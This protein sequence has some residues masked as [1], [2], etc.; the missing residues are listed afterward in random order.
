MA[1]GILAFYGE[2][3]SLRLLTCLLSRCIIESN[4]WYVWCDTEWHYCTSQDTE[5][6]DSYTAD[7]AHCD[8]ERPTSMQNCN[9]A[10][11]Y[12]RVAFVMH[13]LSCGLT[14][15]ND[16]FWL[17]SIPPS[18]WYLD[19]SWVSR[20]NV[21]LSV[22]SKYFQWW[23]QENIFLYSYIPKSRVSCWAD[24]KSFIVALCTLKS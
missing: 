15:K 20:M 23:F 1:I 10:I 14:Q 6:S 7:N 3:I 18:W 21:S 16:I 12:G 19:Y 11:S 24:L 4:L 2:N 17:T 13:S 9:N 22:L 5:N 8:E